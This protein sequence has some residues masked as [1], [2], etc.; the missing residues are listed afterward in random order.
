LYSRIQE[1]QC[2]LQERELT[3]LSLRWR[4]GQIKTVSLSTPQRLYQTSGGIN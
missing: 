2:R 3:G 4:N 1:L